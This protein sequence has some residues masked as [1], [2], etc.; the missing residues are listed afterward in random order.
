MNC[1]AYFDSVYNLKRLF[2]LANAANQQQRGEQTH[3]HGHRCRAQ[4]TRLSVHCAVFGLFHHRK[5]CLDMHG[6]DEDVLR[7]TIE[8]TI[9]A[10]ARADSRNDNGC[11]EY[12]CDYY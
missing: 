5:R 11:R 2:C 3:H 6:A 9:A 1:F 10:G 8:T 7:Q 12:L 4:V